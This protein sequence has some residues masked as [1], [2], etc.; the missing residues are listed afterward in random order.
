MKPAIFLDYK[1]GKLYQFSDNQNIPGEPLSFRN[2]DRTLWQRKIAVGEMF[3]VLAVQTTRL[4]ECVY[5]SIFTKD[6]LCGT[7][8]VYAGEVTEVTEEPHE[9]HC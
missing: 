1:I 3:V 7:I 8:C 6:A 4:E 5:L 2:L 9:Q